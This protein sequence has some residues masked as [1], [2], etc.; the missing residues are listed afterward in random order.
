MK[1]FL[2]L[3]S[4]EIEKE[5]DNDNVFKRFYLIFK[6]NQKNITLKLLEQN[7]NIMDTL[8]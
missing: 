3:H 4:E 1:I 2:F 7:N 8:F 5:Y 6:K